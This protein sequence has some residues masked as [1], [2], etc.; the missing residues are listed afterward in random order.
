MDGGHGPGGSLQ[1]AELIDQFGGELAA[2][3]RR[4]YSIDIRELV[5]GPTDL[6]PGY[7]LQ[8]ITGLPEDSVFVAASQGGP[9][10]RHWGVEEHLLA[11]LFDAVQTL[12]YVTIAA[13]SKKKPKPPEALERPKAQQKTK[14]NLFAVMASRKLAAA[15]KAKESANGGTGR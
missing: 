3:F 15:R 14:S 4:Y 10:F 8:L 12:T 5:S 6:T 9:Q 2:D 13:N 11:N 1:L 7:V